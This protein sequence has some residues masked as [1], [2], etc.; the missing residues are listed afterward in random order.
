M[1]SILI[2]DDHQIVF[3]G[4]QLIFHTSKLEFDLNSSKNGDEAVEA[5]RKN[6]FDLIIMDVNLPD[7]DTYQLLHLILGM[8]PDQKI[9]IFSM[10]SEEM[11]AKRFLKLGAMGYL[12]KQESNEEFIQAVLTVLSG[13][14]Y[15]SKYMIKSMTNDAL[16]GQSGHVFEKLSPRE[17]EIMTY[18]LRGHGSKEVSNITNLHSSTIGTYKFK[19]FDKLGV[20]NIL[21]LQE[22]ARVHDVK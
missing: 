22:L 1:K 17:F 18:F 5:L 16:I 8:Y 19:I 2:I 3:S 13:E 15:L 14:R 6:S 20:K 4:I 21:E 7:T 9:L 11:Y 10:S 12:S